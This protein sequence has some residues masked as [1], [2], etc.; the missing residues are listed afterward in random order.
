[1]TNNS[2]RIILEVA[3]ELL[4]WL[5][6]SCIAFAI[7]FPI[8]RYLHYTQLYTNGLL[9]VIALT[10]FRYTIWLRTTAVLSSKWVRFA[11]FVFNINLF[12]GVL[13]LQQHYMAIYDSFAIEDLGK[14]IHTIAQE[15][16]YP[17]FLYFSREVTVAVMACLILSVALNLRMIAAYWGTSYL[18]LNAGDEE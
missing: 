18:R 11:L 15:A 17:L 12:V 7:M 1:M 3:K 13:R 6:S 10:Y 5:I 16:V 4:W 2:Q 9:L 14:P 8:V